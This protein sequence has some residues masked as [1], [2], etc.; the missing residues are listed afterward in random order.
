MMKRNVIFAV[1]VCAFATLN[2][3]AAVVA[4]PGTSATPSR[5]TASSRIP[6][7]AKSNVTVA[8]TNTTTASDP[9]PATETPEP[10]P[11][12]ENKSAQFNT[13]LD[14]ALESAAD[15]AGT[16]LAERIRAQR[17]ALDAADNDAANAA[18]IA[19]TKSSGRNA[20]DTGLRD[21]M[22]EK[23]GNNFLKCTSDTDTTFG[24]KMD[25][26][27]RNL[28]CSAHEYKLFSAEIKNDRATTI[29]LKS[30]NDIIDCGQDY[31]KCII[32]ECGTT[33]SK[34]LGKSAGDAAIS[35]CAT[36]AK[37]CTKMDN[38][39]ANRIMSVFSTL[40]QT[41]EKQIATDEKKLYALRDQMKSVCSRMGAMFDERSLD[42]VYTVN[43]RAGGE[44]TLYASKKAYAGST[45]DCTPDW[46]GVDV[47]TFKENAYRLTR[48]QTSAS[49]A[50]MGSGV[51][52]AVGAV[53][54]GAVGRAIDRYKADQAVQRAKSAQENS[55]MANQSNNTNQN[56]NN[57]N[58]KSGNDEQNDN[59][60]SNNDQNNNQSGN[61]DNGS[62]SGNQGTES[63]N[64]SASNGEE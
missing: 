54:S 41:A 36:I 38:G 56:N 14:S 31:D 59:Q 50:M 24:T 61:A 64:T 48:E 20:C 22:T 5:A 49:S 33:Y 28:K 30:F 11:V 8:N 40:R 45:F 34:C 10:T 6:T 7:V 26:C 37:N 9:E 27:R 58:D 2:A 35:K 51:G 63:S 23:C 42:C 25:S 62:N 47:T 29:K 13:K 15:I 60:N 44:S 18:A 39:L 55:A 4:R 57:L 1:L 17:A 43:F 3:N 53:T 19:A 32:G 12:I 52:T 21:C 46:F 16:D